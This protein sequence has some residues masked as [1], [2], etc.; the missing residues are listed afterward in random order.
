MTQASRWTTWTGTPWCTWNSWSNQLFTESR[1]Q[2]VARTVFGSRSTV[3]KSAVPKQLC[4]WELQLP[5]WLASFGTC[6]AQHGTV[7]SVVQTSVDG[8]LAAAPKCRRDVLKLFDLLDWHCQQLTL[9]ELC[10]DSRDSCGR[11]SADVA[12]R[13]WSTA[14]EQVHMGARCSWWSTL[15]LM[16]CR[17]VSIGPDCRP[18][19]RWHRHEHELLSLII[20]YTPVQMKLEKCRYCKQ[21]DSQFKVIDTINIAYI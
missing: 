4:G 17:H 13:P 15:S 11:S 14:A 20:L 16:R 9:A 6:L 3:H 2:A 7:S 1:N 19:T 5:C 18:P 8:L 21:T 12:C 10:P